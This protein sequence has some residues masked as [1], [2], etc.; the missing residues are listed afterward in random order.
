MRTRPDAISVLDIGG[1][2]VLRD[3]HGYLINPE[4]WDFD[5]AGKLAM[6]EDIRLTD[7]HLAVLAFMR[8][9]FDEHD[10]AADARFVFTFLADRRGESAADARRHFFELFPYGYVKQACKIAG[11]RQPLAWSTG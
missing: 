9:Y 5:V 1:K 8:R 6:E 10:I 11:M 7:E 3:E 2:Q 4:Q